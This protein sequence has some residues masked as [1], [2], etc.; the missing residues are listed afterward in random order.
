MRLQLI[1]II[2]MLIIGGCIEENNRPEN[3]EEINREETSENERTNETEESELGT[4]VTRIIDGDTVEMDDGSTVR[5]LCVNTAESGKPWYQEGKDFLETTLLNETVILMNETEEDDTDSFGRLLRWIYLR[6]DTETSINQA[7]VSGGLAFVDY[8]ENSKKEE[9]LE[10]ENQAREI[11]VGLWERSE[12]YNRI[13]ITSLAY[14]PDG[15]DRDNMN[16][17]NLTFHNEGDEQINLTGWIIQ[18]RAGH[19]YEF[20]EFVINTGVEFTI[21]CGNGEDNQ[22]EIYWGSNSPIWNNDGDRM[23]LRDI[24]G[25]LVNEFKYEDSEYESGTE[26]E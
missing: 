14:N 18:D 16:G 5:L 21:Y 2:M 15:S 24:N 9:L 22:T 4:I 11:G 3:E 25:Y 17:E 12:Y 13:N 20:S 6:N 23:T 7:L 1:L 8:C 26:I 19:A 10:R